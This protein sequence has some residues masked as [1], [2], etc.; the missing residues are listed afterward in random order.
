MMLVVPIYFKKSSDKTA[1]VVV[2]TVNNFF[3]RWFKE[4]DIRRYPDDVRNLPTNNTVE[5]CNYAAQQTKRLPKNSLNDIKETILYEKK[6]VLLTGNRARRLNNT[7]TPADRTD[8][9]LSE[10][11]TD[12]HG[13]LKEKFYCRIPLGVFFVSLGL[14]NFPLKIDTRV[15]F[16]LETNLNK[17]FKINAK[18]AAIPDNPDAQIIYHDIPY[19]SYQQITLDDNFLAYY[20]GILR[21]RSALKTGVIL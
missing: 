3:T 18:A 15:L 6:A 9:N 4:I 5:V 14:V 12:F 20:N 21:S 11:V 17:L 19:I 1:D 16:M 8:A 2:V 7:G 10:R 13:L